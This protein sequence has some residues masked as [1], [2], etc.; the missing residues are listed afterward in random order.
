L[1]HGTADE[2]RP[3]GGSGDDGGEPERQTSDEGAA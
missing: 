2:P 3:Q 1:G